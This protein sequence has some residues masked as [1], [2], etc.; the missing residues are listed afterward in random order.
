MKRNVEPDGE[1]KTPKTVPKANT[2]YWDS[3]YKKH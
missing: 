3:K 2:K 1:N